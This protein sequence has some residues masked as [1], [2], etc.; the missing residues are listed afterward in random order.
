M[1]ELDIVFSVHQ[2]NGQRPL[3]MIRHRIDTMI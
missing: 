2:K 3:S 1:N